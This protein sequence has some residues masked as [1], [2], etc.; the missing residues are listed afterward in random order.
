MPARAGLATNRDAMNAWRLV[1]PGLC[2]LWLVGC[3]RSREQLHRELTSAQ[4][5]ALVR[6]LDAHYV[7]RCPDVLDVSILGRSGSARCPV[8]AD[9]RIVVDGRAYHVSGQTAPRAAAQLAR[10]LNLSET[11]V[12]V[13]VSQHNSQHLFLVGPFESG[14]QRVSY[15]GPETV[16]ELL[17]RVGLDTNAELTE[18]SVLR[19]HVADGKPPEVFYVDLHAILIGRDTQTNIHLEPS[20][21]VHIGQ[22]R[23]FHVASCLPP[24]MRPMYEAIFGV[25]TDEKEK[26]G[27][28]KEQQPAGNKNDTRASMR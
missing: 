13:R 16:T 23:P 26:K 1:L 10:D 24:V 27:G 5:P 28:K 11:A 21:H 12:R 2:L 25:E 3:S 19:A 22:R 9:G 7:I 14:R 20:D 15:R 6:D 18:V 4:P 8:R 17:R